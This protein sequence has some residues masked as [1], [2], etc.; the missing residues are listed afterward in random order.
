MLGKRE[1][2]VSLEVFISIYRHFKERPNAP[3]DTRKSIPFCQRLDI[4]THNTYS[5]FYFLLH[6][7]ASSQKNFI[8]IVYTSP[9]FHNFTLN[10]PFIE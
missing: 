6:F 1:R 10:P 2:F 8:V 7:R 4:S 9:L 3:H 5:P